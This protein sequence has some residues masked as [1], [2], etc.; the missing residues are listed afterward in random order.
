VIKKVQIIIYSTLLYVSASSLLEEPPDASVYA[1]A[2]TVVATVNFL[3]H[4]SF[5]GA[6]DYNMIKLH[7]GILP[8]IRNVYSI[9]SAYKTNKFSFG[10]AASVQKY[11]DIEEYSLPGE[12]IASYEVFNQFYNVSSAFTFKDTVSIGASANY[13]H[14]Q[15]A[16]SVSSS[17][18]FNAGVLVKTYP[19]Y[20]YFTLSRLFF[21]LRYHHVIE[22][23]TPQLHSGVMLRSKKVYNE[24][25]YLCVMVSG[26]IEM[27][28]DLNWSAAAGFSLP[29]YFHKADI[30]VILSG[31]VEVYKAF[32]SKPG[33]TGGIGFSPGMIQFDYAYTQYMD[34]LGNHIISVGL[35]L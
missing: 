8:G 5:L 6:A 20:M 24:Y 32:P 28:V 11:E 31:G 10:A 1:S 13:L 22:N 18:F 15:M 3:K 16:G 9:T 34:M 35:K 4:P 7:V 23:I 27:S 14:S 12:K 30:E 21:R 2:G 19:V 25:G 17:V 29:F 33:L 26:R